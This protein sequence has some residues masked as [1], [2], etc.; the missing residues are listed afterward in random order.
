[1][2]MGT[3]NLFL[4]ADSKPA[5]LIP[6]TP[7]RAWD[8]AR[9]GV[10]SWVFL[11]F[12]MRSPPPPLASHPQPSPV[13]QMFGRFSRPEVPR[14]EFSPSFCGFPCLRTPGRLGGSFF[15]FPSPALREDLVSHS[16]SCALVAL[17][18]LFP[19]PPP[20][21][22]QTSPFSQRC[23]PSPPWLHA[24]ECLGFFSPFPPFYPPQPHFPSFCQRPLRRQRP[25]FTLMSFV[26]TPH[27]SMFG[28][29]FAF[30]FFRFL[31]FFRPGRTYFS[32][33]FI[34]HLSFLG[35]ARLV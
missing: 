32:P 11:F 23:P 5:W 33:P 22:F 19:I 7:E 31:C 4:K 12:C 25:F 17:F 24:S 35:A 27:G 30:F 3:S 28:R 10:R 1:M 26:P 8:L 20:L 16:G 6:G 18:F 21:E 14:P 29:P 34:G 13:F 9:Q 15:F 2:T